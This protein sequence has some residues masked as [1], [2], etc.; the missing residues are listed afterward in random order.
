MLVVVS[1]VVRGPGLVTAQRRIVQAPACSSTKVAGFDVERRTLYRRSHPKHAHRTQRTAYRWQRTR[2][3]AAEAG[4]LMPM[5][6][7]LCAVVTDQAQQAG[8]RV[9]AS[10]SLA[11]IYAWIALT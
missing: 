4:S 5:Q 11:T 10:T 6:L 1:S 3:E 2:R 7:A 8:Q 9:C